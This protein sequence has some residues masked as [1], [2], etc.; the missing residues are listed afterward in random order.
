MDEVISHRNIFRF[1]PPPKFLQMPSAGVHISD[2]A[3]RVMEFKRV[4]KKLRIKKHTEKKIPA[5]IFENG[6]LVKKDELVTILKAVKSEFGLHF[7]HASLP[8][9][10]AYLFKTTLPKEAAADIHQAIEFKLEENVPI[11][12]ADTLF[13]AYLLPRK[14]HKGEHVDVS[15]C[16]LPRE[17]VSLYQ[18]VFLSA[19]LVPVSFDIE[20]QAV[21]RALI[22]KSD[23]STYLLVNIGTSHSAVS[24]VSEGQVR[25][26]S[27]LSIG[28]D[29]LTSAIARTFGITPEEA[30]A[31]KRE[32]IFIK[33]KKNEEIFS[34]LVTAVSALKDEI[35]KVYSYWENHI[36]GDSE[37]DQEVKK[38]L[39]AGR[40]GS[41]A[42]FAEHLSADMKIKTEVGNVWANVYSFDEKIPEIVLQDSYDYAAAIGLALSS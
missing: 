17:T 22:K 10:K 8:D 31:K 1:F 19:G 12:P 39:L 21:A 37:I 42:G 15:V 4:G 40:D 18:D 11:A 5:G 7:I 24:V 6:E 32:G 35:K 26:T 27:T 14:Q 13:E 20:A 23:F 41:L 33:N 30:L 36:G 9:E 2:E 38:I 3:I 25:F 16:A 29:T 34:A 28:S